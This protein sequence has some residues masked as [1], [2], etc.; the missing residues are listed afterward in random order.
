V[1]VDFELISSLNTTTYTFTMAGN[2]TCSEGSYIIPAYDW[3]F[4][5]L[6]Q[7][8]RRY[9]IPPGAGGIEAAFISDT[10]GDETPL[11]KTAANVLELAVGLAW[12]GFAG[13]P[14]SWFQDNPRSVDLYPVPDADVT[15]G[16][17][18]AA[19][20][21]RCFEATYDDCDLYL[22][23]GFASEHVCDYA[24]DLLAMRI[25]D[26][27]TAERAIAGLAHRRAELEKGVG[28]VAQYIPPALWDMV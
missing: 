1:E 22:P 25:G 15:S 28:D 16:L 4:R 17:R 9:T 7:Y 18:V 6:I 2:V 23:P 8:Q 12:T 19:L 5:D 14:V 26:T 21:E 13:T 27:Q 11:M 20:W 24:A 10:T 3:P